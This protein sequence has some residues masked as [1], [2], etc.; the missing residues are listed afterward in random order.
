MKVNYPVGWEV[1]I[2][3]CL[4][5]ASRWSKP[6][7][8][9][10][11][12]WREEMR[13]VAM[14]ALWSAICSYDS[15]S[16]VDM[17]RFVKSRVKAALLQRYR[18][19]WRFAKRCCLSQPSANELS[20]GETPSLPIEEIPE[21]IDE[22]VLWWRME[23][24][25]ILGSLPPKDH[26]LLERLFIDGTT[27]SDIAEELGISQPTVSRWKREIIQKLQQMLKGLRS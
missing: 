5:E 11:K 20:D 2:D 3:E 12:D 19:E 16:Q 4:R 15:R 6:P 26:Y 7:N 9:S 25:N 13:A 1:W 21:K 18:E 10:E 17:N 23:V 14:L 27:E 24:R 22:E 8:W